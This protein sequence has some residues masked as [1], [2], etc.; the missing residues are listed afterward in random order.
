MSRNISQKHA[1]T[2]IVAVAVAALALA[3]GARYGLIENGVLP[4]DCTAPGLEGS[5]LCS[6][7]W[8]LVQSF[9]HQRMGIFALACGALAFV[10]GCRRFA[11]AGWATGLAGLVLYNY[12]Y[13]AVGA[14]LA[15][16][17]LAAAGEE[18]RQAQA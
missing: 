5:G 9:Q 13:A 8:V 15:L 12:D 14:L 2:T 10:T 1:W 7:K 11:W 18:Q 4:R 6:V 17:V 3:L 16:L